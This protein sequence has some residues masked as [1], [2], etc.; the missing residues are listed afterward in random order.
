MVPSTDGRSHAT[1]RRHLAH[2]GQHRCY[3]SALGS[4]ARYL[5]HHLHPRLRSPPVLSASSGRSHSRSHARQSRLCALQ[6]RLLFTHH[7]HHPLFPRGMLHRLPLLPRRNLR[8]ASQASL[9]GHSLLPSD[10]S[11][12]SNGNVSRRHRLSSDLLRQLRPSHRL[13]FHRTLRSGQN[14]GRRLAPASPLDDRR[15]SS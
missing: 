12:W 4:A 13:H 6:G 3:P 9:R 1:R 8:S 14:L 11:R 15:H 5:P 7:P 10:R 2:H